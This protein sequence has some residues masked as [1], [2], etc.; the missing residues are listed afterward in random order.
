MKKIPDNAKRVF[1]GIIYD[2]YQWEQEMFDGSFETF[3][4]LKRH[5][6]VVVMPFDK[7]GNV[8]YARQEQ[9]HFNEK[10]LS[11]FGG[12]SE[13]GEDPLDAIKRE[14]QEESGLV[15]NDWQLFSIDKGHRKIDYNVH[16]YIAKNC[17]FLSEP[18]LDS[19]EKIEILKTT[20]EDFMESVVPADDF[21]ERTFKSM[22]HD[23]SE[24][25]KQAFIDKWKN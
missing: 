1:K 8:F 12:R 10:Y 16:Y 5:D 21:I 19:G 9:P 15:S 20:I 4:A 17:E 14:L 24:E 13:D 18:E 11:L 6:T 22:F 2:V 3:E 23:F 25:K 7:D